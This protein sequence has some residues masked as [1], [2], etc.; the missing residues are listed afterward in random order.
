MLAKLD[1]MISTYRNHRTRT[2]VL[3]GSGSSIRNITGP[4]WKAIA[5]HDTWTTNNWVY[6]PF[7]IPK[8]YM[9]ETKWYGYDILARRFR[10]KWEQYKDTN[11]LFAYGKR[12]RMRDGKKPYLR[13]VVPAG[14]NRYEYVAMP[15]DPKRTHNP[16]NANYKPKEHCLTKSYD[17][18]MTLMFELLYKMGYEEVVLFGID[19]HD[20]Y[21]FW[22]GGET[23]Y[24]EVHH[25]TN[26]E[27]EGRD[28]KKPHAT[29]RIADFILDFQS[30]WMI[31]AKRSIHV[32][33]QNTLLFPKLKYRDILS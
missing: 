29:Y 24:G 22:S 12:I 2:A 27:H 21:Y 11:F 9:V 30:R 20:G 6:H 32:G 10:Q 7:F 5:K 8:F 25:R 16:F 23:K 4:Q 14:A 31:P 26:K 3:L 28:P 17:M 18:S 1:D 19:L 33:H 13:D 15:R